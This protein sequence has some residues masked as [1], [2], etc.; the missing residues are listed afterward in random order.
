MAAVTVC[1]DFG[2]QEN[3]ICHSFHSPPFYLPWSQFDGE[4]KSVPIRKIC[5][6]SLIIKEMKIKGTMQYHL[7]SVRMATIR[8]Q[9]QENNVKIWYGCAAVGTLL[10]YWGD[11]K[12]VQPRWKAIWQFLKKLKIGL[13]HDSPIPLLGIYPKGLKTVIWTA[14]Y[15][16]MFVVE[17]FTVAKGKKQ[18]KCSWMDERIN[19]MW[20][21]QQWHVILSLKGRKVWHRLQRGG[22][23]KTLCSVK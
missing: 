18:P 15:M 12:M 9:N 22:S 19:G 11:Y 13:S 1:S 7:T 21:V 3:K 10:H 5:P 8:K 17:M 20:S 2:A 14:I 4:C 16:P 23:L 6:P